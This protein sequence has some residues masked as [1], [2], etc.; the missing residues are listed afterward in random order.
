MTNATT[1]CSARA[2]D[3][4]VKPFYYVNTSREFAFGSEI[5]QLLPLIERRIAED[6]LV[7]D[8]LVCG[9]TDHTNRTFFKGIEKLPPG[10]LLRVDV[11]TGQ[12]KIERYYSLAPR[13]TDLDDEKVPGLVRDLLDDATRLRLRSDVRVGT[14]LSGGLDSSTRRNAGRKASFAEFQRGLLCDYGREPAGEQQ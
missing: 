10:H 4:G 11:P 7:N 6:D 12:I 5:R 3:F 14:C 1:R 13:P 2:I 9:L 8:F